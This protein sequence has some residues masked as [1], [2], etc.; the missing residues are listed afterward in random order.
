[1]SLLTN[2]NLKRT[3]LRLILFTFSNNGRVLCL[4]VMCRIKRGMQKVDKHILPATFVYKFPRF[5]TDN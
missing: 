4:R 2:T 5:E 3:T 1:M